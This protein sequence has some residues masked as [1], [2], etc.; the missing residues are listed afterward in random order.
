MK[1]YITPTNE[2]LG[3]DEEQVAQGYLPQGSVLVPSTYT[4]QQYPYLTLQSGKI[5]FDAENYDVFYNTLQ[6]DTY[7]FATQNLLDSTA[8]SWGYDNMVSAVSYVGSN[9]AQ[10]AAEGTALSNWRD[11]VWVKVAEIQAGPL[12]ATTQDFL[13]L[14][15]P[16][17]N[18]PVA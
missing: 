18:K 17:P 11:A 9:N 13:L 2:I 6:V 7:N 8:Q 14:L 10:F 5:V 12:P 15:P 4:S 1:N 3:L 16:A